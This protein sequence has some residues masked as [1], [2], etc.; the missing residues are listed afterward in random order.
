MKIENSIFIVGVPRSGTTLLYRLL[1]QHS[2]L[3]WFSEEDE[4]KIL[5]TEFIKKSDNFEKIKKNILEKQKNLT[6]NQGKD[7]IPVPAELSFVYD[8][9][10]SKNWKVKVSDQNLEILINEITKLIKVD[11][12]KRY[13]CKTPQN[14]IRIPKI[15]EIFPNSKFLH[16]LRDPRAV[17][18]SLLERVQKG[19]SNYFGIPIKKKLGFLMNSVEKHSLQWKQV[20][21]EIIKASKELESNQFFQIKYEELT[22]KTDYW[23]EKITNFCELPPFDY[24]YNKEGKVVN[25]EK[26]DSNEWGYLNQPTITNRNK[27]LPNFS[28]IEK[29]TIPLSRELG[30]N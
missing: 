13:L 18:N 6:T 30:Y 3:V 14:S 10:F 4:K 5:T 7:T 11:E 9:V 15:N 23:L 8:E 16:I 19:D 17:V 12:K 20:V 28:Q 29:H 1:A 27:T 21:K 2:N 26:K 22:D 25:L 24:I